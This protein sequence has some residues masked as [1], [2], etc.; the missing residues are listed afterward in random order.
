MTEDTDPMMGED[1]EV[2]VLV[3]LEVMAE[4]EVAS[5]VGV[6]EEEEEAVAVEEQCRQMVPTLCMWVTCHTAW[7]RETWSSS[8]K[9]SR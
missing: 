1:E 6:A 7:S 5:E 4:V 2:E 8:S 3:V 9:I